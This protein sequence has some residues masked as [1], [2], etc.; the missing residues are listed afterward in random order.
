LRLLE[1]SIPNVNFRCKTA[2]TIVGHCG[3]DFGKKDFIGPIRA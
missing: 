3:V 2:Y 1:N